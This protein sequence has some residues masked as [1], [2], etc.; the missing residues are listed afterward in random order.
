MQN[1]RRNLLMTV[2]AV[3]SVA[4][5]LFLTGAALLLRTGENKQAERWKGGV[6]LSIFMK[7]DSTQEQLNAVSAQLRDAPDIKKV[8]S[9]DKKAAYE[10]MRR[11][12]E[13]QP[14]VL[15]TIEEKD[16]P[17]SFRLVPK[18]VDTV[19]EI[20]NRFKN[21]PGVYQVVYAKDAIREAS[22]TVQERQLAFAAMAVVFLFVAILLIFNTVH[23]TIFGRR[24]E[25]AI[26]KLVGATNWFIRVPFML[27]GLVQGV[28]GAAI[29]AVTVFLLKDK[30]MSLV[31]DV[32]LGALSRLSIT[33]GEAAVVCAILVVL[34][35]VFGMATSGFAVRRYLDV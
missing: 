10:E 20:G 29:A 33:A 7:P 25:V 14:E 19:D 5:A 21:Q 6:E 32:G 24:R 30:L 31:A 22:K 18:N 34:G 8:V 26:M 11:L 9:V 28:I 16:A 17:A 4:L 23:L 3:V 2:A 1:L 13:N 15:A 27:E 12:F 35:A